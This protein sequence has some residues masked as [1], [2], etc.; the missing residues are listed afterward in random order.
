MKERYNH[1]D[2]KRLPPLRVI[3]GKIKGRRIE[4]PPGELDIRPMTAKVRAALFNIIGDCTGMNMLDLFCGSGSIS[5]EAFSRGVESSDLVELD[6]NRKAIIEKNLEHS[7]FVNGKH[8]V[9][10]VIS[11]CERTEKKYDFI[12]MDPPYIW[13][14]KEELI[15]LIS[16]KK[17]LTEKGFLVIQLPRK[18][19]ISEEI[20][21]LIRYD[22]RSYGLNTLMFYKRK[23][24]VVG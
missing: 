3:A 16:D 21:D 14:K 17:L 1:K 20:G 19:Q 18:Y 11:F 13:D 24:E 8:F 5:I 10:D 15:M 4:F 6:R 12:M 9:S 23:D 7:G 2:G 22:M